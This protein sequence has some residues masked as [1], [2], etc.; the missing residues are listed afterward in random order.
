MILL[1]GKYFFTSFTK[2]FYNTS[3]ILSHFRGSLK[4][5]QKSKLQLINFADSR[6]TC[7]Y[8]CYYLNKFL[9]MCLATYQQLY[10]GTGEPSKAQ[11]HKNYT[12]LF[13][14]NILN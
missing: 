9:R 1:A 7:L 14:M 8:A 10:N 2:Y 6:L 5:K 4:E 13:R 11:I 12:T 3:I